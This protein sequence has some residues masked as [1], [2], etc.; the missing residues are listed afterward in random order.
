M[1]EKKNMWGKAEEKSKPVTH[2]ELCCLIWSLNTCAGYKVGL[3]QYLNLFFFDYNQ[4]DFPLPS[5]LFLGNKN[6]P[7]VMRT[8]FFALKEQ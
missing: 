6:T 7:R 8:C 5:S 3:Q 4:F 1:W 2:R